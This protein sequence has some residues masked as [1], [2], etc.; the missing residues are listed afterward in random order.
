[1][2]YPLLLPIYCPSLA[3][4]FQ[5]LNAYSSIYSFVHSFIWPHLRVYYH[6][7]IQEVLSF[8]DRL[9]FEPQPGSGSRYGGR[10]GGREGGKEEDTV[11]QMQ[12]NSC[13]LNQ[14]LA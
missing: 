5:Y 3:Y 6:V 14:N 8:V 1:M 7:I 4:L 2:C 10:E 9:W 12:A 11:G 13:F